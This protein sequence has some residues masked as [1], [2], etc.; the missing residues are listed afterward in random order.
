MDAKIMEIDQNG[1][2]CNDATCAELQKTIDLLKCC[3]REN[4]RL[5]I[6]TLGPE[7]T[8]SDLCCQNFIKAILNGNAE[9]ILFP[10]YEAAA[11][12]VESGKTDLL[13][14]ANAYH[15]INKFYISY[16]LELTT[17]FVFDTAEYGIALKQPSMFSESTSHDLRKFVLYTHPAPAHLI[18]NLLNRYQFK[19]EVRYARS[20]SEAAR[21][22]ASGKTDLCLTN[23]LA[24]TREGLHI[25]TDTY[26][27]KMLWSVFK[28]RNQS[29]IP[30]FNTP[31]IFSADA[32]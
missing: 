2:T 25:G 5:I 14:V 11:Y 26:R 29:K 13:L 4:Q 19:Y 9:C 15:K 23:A 24:A 6:A 22:V 18:P 1:K 16:K 32:R 28:N 8:S 21:L 10:S 30:K 20:T 7:D 27:I 17:F 31:Q 3:S 12:S